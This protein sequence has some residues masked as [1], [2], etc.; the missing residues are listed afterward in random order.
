MKQLSKRDQ[1]WNNHIEAFLDSGL[2]QK[3]YCKKHGINHKSFSVRKSEYFKRQRHLEGQDKFIPLTSP[4]SI[5]IK[6]SNGAEL[7]FDKTPD[8]S[9][10]GAI[11]KE[12]DSHA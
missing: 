1:F 12:M 9:W 7:S 2:I 3:D 4:V 10:I 6:L 8:P 5:K 11:L